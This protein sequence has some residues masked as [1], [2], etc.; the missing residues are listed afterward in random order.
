[1]PCIHKR[2]APRQVA[3]PHRRLGRAGLK[4]KIHVHMQP[5]PTQTLPPLV[6]LCSEALGSTILLKREDLQPVKS[7][8]LRGAY[9]KMAQLTQ[10]QVGPPA[11]T[12]LALSHPCGHGARRL[13]ASWRQ[14]RSRGWCCTHTLPATAPA[15]DG[16]DV[17]RAGACRGTWPCALQ[18]WRRSLAPARGKGMNRYALP[19]RAPG[20][21]L[22]GTAA[23]ALTC[24]LEPP[25]CP[26]QLERGVIC[27]SAGNHAQGVALAARQ[28]VSAAA[29]WLASA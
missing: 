22:P 15:A 26:L 14:C 10:E 27:S 28:L 17:G 13:R 20:T 16:A 21:A 8:K 19:G 7:F 2:A 9:N 29:A 23:W 12:A 6:P 25:P 4:T 24:V 5:P 1:M 3:A 18:G 11:Q